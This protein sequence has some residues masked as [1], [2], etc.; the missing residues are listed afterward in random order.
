MVAKV[1]SDVYC[2]GIHKKPIKSWMNEAAR[3]GGG[4]PPQ[5]ER[6]ISCATIWQLSPP[7]PA[8]P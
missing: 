8:L 7:A 6:G 1:L 5:R 2:I 3:C 4:G